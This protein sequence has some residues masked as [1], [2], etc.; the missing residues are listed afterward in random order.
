MCLQCAAL[1]S[2]YV[3]Y[4]TLSVLLS[5]CLII[6]SDSSD[7]MWND[8]EEI[9]SLET[10]DSAVELTPSPP[11]FECNTTPDSQRAASLL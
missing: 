1:Y 6:Q 11:Q 7:K 5:C 8:D 3:S 2:L 10:A 4:E 9:E